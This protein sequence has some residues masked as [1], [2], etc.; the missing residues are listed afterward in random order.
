MSIKRILSDNARRLA[1]QHSLAHRS[2]VHRAHRSIRPLSGRCLACDHAG[3]TWV[4]LRWCLTCGSVLC[5][6]SSPGRH[7]LRHYEETGHPVIASA[8]GNEAWGWCYVD[9]AYLS[10]ARSAEVAA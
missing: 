1:F 2:C 10:D 4:H 5:C 7:A 8:E 9:Q 6:D 3:T